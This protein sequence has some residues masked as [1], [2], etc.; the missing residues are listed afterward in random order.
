MWREMRVR[1]SFGGWDREG[2]KESIIIIWV[3]CGNY[4]IFLFFSID[5]SE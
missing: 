1:Y 4:F 3:I 5:S 2:E